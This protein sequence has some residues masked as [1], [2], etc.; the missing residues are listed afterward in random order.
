MNNSVNQISNLASLALA[1][2]PLLIIVA[3]FNFGAVSVAGL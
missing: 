2:L 1:V 3:A